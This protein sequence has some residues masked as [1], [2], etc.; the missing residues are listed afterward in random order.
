MN[1]KIL[2]IIL[3][4]AMILCIVPIS[5]LAEDDVPE[6]FI[7]VED[8]QGNLILPTDSRISV[9]ASSNTLTINGSDLT[10]LCDFSAAE[11]GVD[12]P[13]GIPEE[14]C[15]LVIN[16][17]GKITILGYDGQ[18]E[19]DHPG[20][21]TG[22]LVKSFTLNKGDVN[23]VTTD[24]YEYGLWCKGLFTMNDGTLTIDSSVQSLVALKCD[25]LTM[26]NG[27]IDIKNTARA[28][29]IEVWTGHGDTG[30]FVLKGGS[31]NIDIPKEYSCALMAEGDAYISGGTITSLSGDGLGFG[32]LEMTGGSIDS[33]ATYELSGALSVSGADISNC[34]LKLEADC[35]G[36]Y[37]LKNLQYNRVGDKALPFKLHDCKVTAV[38]NGENSMGIASFA[39]ME[40][41]NVDLY[42]S[43]TKAAVATCNDPEYYPNFDTEHAHNFSGPFTFPSE[44]MLYASNT[45]ND[46]AQALSTPVVNCEC[47]LTYGTQVVDSLALSADGSTPA[48]TVANNVYEMLDGKDQTWTKGSSNGLTF[49][50]AADFDKFQK[51]LVDNKEVDKTNYTVK[52][53]STIV[54]LSAN[55]LETLSAGKHRI[56]IVSTNG[57]AITEFTIIDPTVP[58]PAVEDE[59]IEN[60]DAPMG[61][62]STATVVL[63]MASVTVLGL[64]L[65]VFCTK[66]ERDA[67]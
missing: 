18:T 56:Q 5:A 22:L 63:A 55:F 42:A 2:T 52:E 60:T 10:I 44:M 64:G 17:D 45:Q 13:I 7:I 14:E 41:S 30:D 37:A 8:S 43:A 51:V 12:S 24:G 9:D 66:K 15:N 21:Y 58:D 53:G 39:G 29:G 36:G 47:T 54:E 31:I 23:F 28:D 16:S 38:A 27:K 50:S 62:V 3:A 35:V 11:G 57:Y 1:K 46:E 61:F 59:I 40:F 67:G 4:L 25:A 19:G 26:T 6:L 34:V 65:I 33:K 32:Y 20:Y 48:L 49:K